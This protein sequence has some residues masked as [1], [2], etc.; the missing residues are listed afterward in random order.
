[1]FLHQG[2]ETLLNS[3]N[4]VTNAIN[5]KSI[6]HIQIPTH[7]TAN[8]STKLTGRCIA[9]SAWILEVE[10]DEVVSIQNP[11]LVVIPTV[12][13]K[14]R[15]RATSGTTNSYKHVKRYDTNS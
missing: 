14:R 6:S 13:F 4:A 15:S 12:H 1:M 9:T 5:L 11:K 7:C 8:I 10:I 2:T 3:I